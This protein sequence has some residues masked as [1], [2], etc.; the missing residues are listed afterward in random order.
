MTRPIERVC[1]TVWVVALAA[2][3]I[4]RFALP[5]APDALT[6]PGCSIGAW[7]RVSCT[8]TPAD[9]TL[10][11]ILT[12]ATLWTWAI[13]AAAWTAYHAL[14]A[15]IGDLLAP[16]FPAGALDR[17]LLR[18]TSLVLAVPFAVAAGVLW[19]RSLM[20]A[21]RVAGR[22]LAALAF[23]PGRTPEAAA[24]LFPTTTELSPADRLRPAC[25]RRPGQTG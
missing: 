4:S 16:L 6:G 15:L 11:A 20:L 19:A 24:W 22:C 21:L 7:F 5:S 10:G 23:A 8:G 1:F 9:A 25:A 13:P 12:F 18:G 17:A 2:G 14:V 3:S